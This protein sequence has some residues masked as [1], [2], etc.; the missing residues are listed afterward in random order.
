M[1]TRIQMMQFA[2]VLKYVIE[3]MTGVR[4]FSEHQLFVLMQGLSNKDRTGIWKLV[5]ARINSSPAEVHDYFFNTWQLQFYQD[6]SV[7]KEELKALFYSQVG[8]SKDAK[9]A[10][11]S[12][13][14]A[15]QLQFPNNN[16]NE[17][18]IYQVLYR[19]AVVKPNQEKK[20][21]MNTMLS[22]KTQE[23]YPIFNSYAFQRVFQQVNMSE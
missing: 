18:K 20:K 8:Y 16:C 3:R 12:T 5:A 9:E 4:V 17:R 10:I 22:E 21:Q 6:P 19:Y 14:E 23:F 11:N 13:I 15:F 2:E 7:Y 1:F